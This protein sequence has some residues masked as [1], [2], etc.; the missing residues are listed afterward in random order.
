MAEYR[1]GLNWMIRGWSCLTLV[2]I[3][4]GALT[5]GEHA[6]LSIPDWPLA[7]GRLVPPFIGGIR[8][9]Y[10]HR[11]IAT[12]VGMISIIVALWLQ[13]KEQRRWLRWLGWGAVLG[14]ILQGV[15]GGLTVLLR[16]PD[17][18]TAF[19][20]SVAQLFFLLTVALAV[21]TGHDWLSLAGE[22]NR[23]KGWIALDGWSL[24][25]TLAILAQIL[26]GAAYR[27]DALGILPHVWG[28]VVVTLLVITAAAKALNLAGER[29]GLR[30]P[31]LLLL[32]ILLAQIGLGI[33]TYFVKIA[34]LN[35]A[36]PPPARVI[37]AT[38]H[39][40]GGSFLL[41]TAFWLALRA[42]Q[43]GAGRAPEAR[44][45]EVIEA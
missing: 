45:E 39:L 6:G 21:F 34:T 9:E 10:T 12:V 24:A 38:L 17:W 44:T 20:A 37:L 41:A 33:W 22:E 5:A 16:Q 35:A 40:V 31:A 2:L 19:H 42:W 30:A 27:H 13:K 29:P 28:A 1:P 32:F 8:F 14:V 4:V 25:A 15:L 18:L 26:L 7:Y 23:V 11:V 36:Q 43:A 3:T